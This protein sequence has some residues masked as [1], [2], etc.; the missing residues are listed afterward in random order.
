V[1]RPVVEEDLA[2]GILRKLVQAVGCLADALVPVRA[3]GDE[4]GGAR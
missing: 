2:P 4:V 1:T 3:D